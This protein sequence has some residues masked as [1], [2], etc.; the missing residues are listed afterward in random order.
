MSVID[1]L[2]GT[3]KRD[4]RLDVEKPIT[5]NIG[6]CVYDRKKERIATQYSTPDILIFASEIY[7]L[8][9]GDYLFTNPIMINSSEFDNGLV[10]KLNPIYEDKNRKVLPYYLPLEKMEGHLEFVKNKIIESIKNNFWVE[11]NG[12]KFIKVSW[13]IEITNEYLNRSPNLQQLI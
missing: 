5:F 10:A 3:Q 6:I 1:I 12:E 4:T 9:L 11:K 8:G 2:L 13:P 7:D